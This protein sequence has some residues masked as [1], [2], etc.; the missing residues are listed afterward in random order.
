MSPGE[1]AEYIEFFYRNNKILV[2]W[3]KVGNLSALVNKHKITQAKE[4]L[5]EKLREVY[6]EYHESDPS[7]A[8]DIIMKFYTMN[9]QDRYS[10]GDI[11]VLKKG[12]SRIVGICEVIGKYEYLEDSL[13]P[14]HEYNHSRQ[15]KFLWYDP[16][17][18]EVSSN[19]LVPYTLEKLR[20]DKF[21]EIL[22][23]IEVKNDGEEDMDRELKE[24]LDNLLDRNSQLIL[25]GPPG[26][27][28]T[29][30]AYKYVKS[31][32]KEDKPGNRWDFITFHQSYSYE[33]F[34]EGFRPVSQGEKIVYV[35]ED[36]IFKKMT[37]KAI[38]EALKRH[39]EMFKETIGEL[40]ELS[41]CLKLNAE[42]KDYRRY[43]E[44]KKKL[45]E[46]LVSLSRED[47]ESLFKDAPEF[48]LIIDEINRGNISKIFGELIT[49]LENDKRI[50]EENEIIITLPYSREPF[51]VPPNLYI[52]GTMNTADRSIALLDVALRRRF[53]FLEIEPKPEKLKDK[54]IEGINLEEL[55][56]KLNIKIEAIKDRD[57]RIGHSYFMKVK[58]LEDL[59]FAWY[60]EIVPLLMEY[61]YNDWDSLRWL[62]G[63]EFVKEVIPTGK[64]NTQIE[65]SSIYKI[66]R[67][68]LETEKND[69]IKA[70]QEVINSVPEVS[71]GTTSRNSES[72]QGSENEFQQFEQ[73]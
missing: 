58:T 64:F 32:T 48:Y 20:W 41:N 51:G 40:E 43:H 70:L 63:S 5:K 67:Y 13:I 69:F 45:W 47:K 28:K 15:V 34:V 22:S 33:E 68:D 17:G 7:K 30:M 61:F 66:K 1:D 29:Y 10:G 31:K 42:I 11:V 35:V 3:G 14:E 6:P 71:E 39:K 8:A 9:N 72:S 52:I 24:N 46:K 59:W 21:W 27:G 37:L 36:G 65:A 25:Y 56:E 44:L 53:A 19:G 57:H 55:L 4:I 26:T 54:N 73:S 2:G 23:K 38:V 16:N 18:I 62:L 50:G 60:Y 49:L 12:K